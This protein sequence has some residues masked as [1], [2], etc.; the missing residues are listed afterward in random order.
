MTAP[1]ETPPPTSIEVDTEVWA[2]L[3]SDPLSVLCGRNN[4][5][6]S[7][8]LRRLLREM[9]RSASYLGPARYQNFNTLAPYG[10]QQ[11]RLEQKW[12]RFRQFF[13]NNTQ[14]IDNSPINLQQAI[15]E[16]S[17]AQ[18][19]VL[20][21]VVGNLLGSDMHLGHTIPGNEMSQKYIQVDGFNLS[22]TSSGFRLVTT[23]VTSLLDKDY[24]EF[25][26]DEPELGLSPEIQG[27]FAEFLLDADARR[28]WFPH[29]KCVVLAT[30]S[31][32]FLDRHKIPNNYRVEREGTSVRVEPLS[33][34]QELNTLQFRLLGNRFDTLYLP[35]AIV[36]VEGKT[37][38]AYLSRLLAQRFPKRAISVVR[39]DNDSRMRDVL[40]IA[41]QMLGDIRTS[42][43]SDRIF[44]VLDSVHMSGLPE[45][46]SAQG[47]PERHVIKWARNGIEY[48]YPEE[49]LTQK[50]GAFKQ[51]A[52]QDDVVSAN[53]IEV[54]K[55]ELS[56]FV[57]ARLNGDTM[58]P[59]ELKAKLLVPLETAITGPT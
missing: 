30:H 5:G 1:F 9:G 35:S 20:F 39:C 41:M 38:H 51:L 59:E 3:K 11:N 50:F 58:V 52:V 57:V 43:Y 53:G 2:R 16:L 44:A 45:Q 6:K 48:L 19:T 4:S 46:L 28:K 27:V 12:R 49:I 25:L 42:P 40:Y 13:E 34:V 22:F 8:V 10:P 54:K 47:I 24:S 33:T 55:G 15:A 31:P 17:D 14:N 36:L 21:E 7:F 29:L 26:V 56:E 18:R 32:I 37:D 23:L